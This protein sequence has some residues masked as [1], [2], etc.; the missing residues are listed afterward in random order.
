[1]VQAATTPVGSAPA[2]AATWVNPVAAAA[3]TPQ[4]FS[5][6][7]APAQSPTVVALLTPVQ[8]LDVAVAGFFDSVGQLLS[9]LP[10]GR[11]TDLFAGALLLVRRSLFNQ[12]PSVS[13][14]TTEM[15][16]DGQIKGTLRVVDPE[17][18]PLSFAVTT[19]PKAGTVQ[20]DSATGEFTYAP[21]P[22]YFGGDLFTVTV[23]D[24]GFN[25][26]EPSRTFTTEV[27]VTVGAL[28]G[29][30]YFEPFRLTVTNSTN[31]PVNVQLCG[32][33]YSGNACFTGDIAVGGSQTAQGGRVTGY[34]GSPS[35]TF[36]GTNEIFL[37]TTTI[38]LDGTQV[39]YS[40]F[41]EGAGITWY[42]NVGWWD[43]L[44]G[45]EESAW[46]ADAGFSSLELR[47][48]SDAT[49]SDYCSSDCKVTV[50]KLNLK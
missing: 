42:A 11:V 23:T 14:T 45:R 7:S 2:L 48:L 49:D 39:N 18:G 25:I 10:A 3:P 38:S 28:V 36:K 27:D 22:D 26:F 46:V 31:R 29:A 24:P 33:Q 40:G 5:A 16:V 17:G 8:K 1:M 35:L 21:G 34:L 50:M 32:S 9:G 13:P 15:T 41:T 44:W 19:A 30:G 4:L 12:A 6:S 47:R 37:P 43:S 20:I